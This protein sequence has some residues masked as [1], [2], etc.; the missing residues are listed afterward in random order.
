MKKLIVSLVILI[1]NWCLGVTDCDAKNE[2]VASPDGAVSM[3]EEYNINGSY[4]SIEGIT[5]PDGRIYGKMAHAER[6][7]DKVAINIYGEQD[8]K[9]FEYG[10]EYFK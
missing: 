9:I 8:L 7:G 4:R 1:S 2:M 6:R 10:V 5:S 3:D